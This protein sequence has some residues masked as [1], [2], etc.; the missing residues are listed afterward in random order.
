MTQSQGFKLGSNTKKTARTDGMTGDV[1]KEIK[2]SD[3]RISEGNLDKS[4]PSLWYKNMCRDLNIAESKHVTQVLSQV[5]GWNFPTL[6]LANKG[7]KSIVPYIDIIRLNHDLEVL[8]L[9]DNFL[10]TEDIVVLAGV[11]CTERKLT[12]VDVSGNNTCA[13]RGVNAFASLLTRNTNI[14][15]FRCRGTV[16][17]MAVR[18]LFVL[19]GYNCNLKTITPQVY[20]AFKTIFKKMDKSGDGHI[21]TKELLKYLGSENDLAALLE[22]PPDPAMQ[23]KKPK[24]KLQKGRSVRMNKK[25]KTTSGT[26]ALAAEIMCKCN[27]G[28]DVA[29]ELD[30]PELLRLMYPDLSIAIITRIVNK[31]EGRNTHGSSLGAGLSLEEIENLFTSLDEDG[32]GTM[33]VNELKQGISKL[34]GG[35][36]QWQLWQKVMKDLGISK[37]AEFTFDEFV[38]LIILFDVSDADE[39]CA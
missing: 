17:S 1:L 12:N 10:S 39:K 33:S 13:T 25:S 8:N 18:P 16:P 30:L 23:N 9:K 28:D 22:A 11:L 24:A 5:A 26:T 4:S 29:A 38:Q 36:K 27:V 21:S 14:T 20:Q 32:N 6:N 35:G 19:V 34:K 7:I 3:K 2:A 15:S 31:Y 37:D